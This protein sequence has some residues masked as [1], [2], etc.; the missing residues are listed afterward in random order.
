[1]KLI[2]T[3]KANSTR[4]KKKHDPVRIVVFVCGA[5]LMSLE[6]A[7]GRLLTPTYGSTVYLWGSIIGVFLLS[8]SFGYY[9]GG[10]FSDKH[11]KLEYLNFLILLNSL[12]IFSVPFTYL[13][14]VRLFEGAPEVMAPLFTVAFLFFIPSFFFGF[15]S[16]FAVKLTAHNLREIG[17]LSGRLYAIAT[18]GSVLGTF[19][20]TF[21]LFSFFS[22]KT[23]IVAN[24]LVLVLASLFISSKKWINILFLLLI[25]AISVFYNL[26]NLGSVEKEN[27]KAEVTKN[28]FYGEVKVT[29]NET[30]GVRE[31]VIDNQTMC[32]MNVNDITA[33]V[34]GWE[35][36]ECLEFP[37][38]VRGK[39][40]N[41]LTI[42]LGCGSFEKNILSKYNIKVDTVEISP[43]VVA[44][45]KNYFDVKESD[46]FSI[47][48]DDGRKFLESSSKTY[49]L[50]ALDAFRV[51]S[52][53]AVP[54]HL[55]TKEF[56]ELVSERLG[57]DGVLTMNFV[58]RN[59]KVGFLNSVEKTIG[60]VFEKVCIFNC[61]SYVVMASKDASMNCDLD[62]FTKEFPLVRLDEAEAVI[63]TD[64]YAPV[65][66]FIELI[67]Q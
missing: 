67:V 24:C 4:V 33:V 8:L 66:N 65:N 56:F 42:G 18:M 49:D 5:V 40:K 36:I 25:L 57:S 35:Y 20:T 38:L 7:A 59:E 54:F 15:V 39:I 30:S 63:L 3:K 29:L 10:K 6:I 12:F 23:I 43:E 60:S 13:S 58:S 55:V 64:D 41:V 16:P 44:V 19:L 34:P 48:T 51:D 9:A 61:G 50:I 27:L 22:T 31:L 2:N 14:V 1:M 11:P 32:A 46:K 17:S 62:I 45:A 37:L 26:L 53:Y 28:S 21:V 47:F 52:D